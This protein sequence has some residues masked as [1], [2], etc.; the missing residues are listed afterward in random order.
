M[1]VLDLL[2]A[3]FPLSV[4]A[5]ES[6]WLIVEITVALSGSFSYSFLLLG[7]GLSRVDSTD[8]ASSELAEIISETIRFLVVRCS[9]W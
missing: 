7:F 8:L 3:G 1:Q 4:K 5:I 9:P 6:L 2:V